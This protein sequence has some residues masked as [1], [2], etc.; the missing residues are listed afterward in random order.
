MQLE[1]GGR[2]STSVLFSEPPLRSLLPI[3]PRRR[4][5]QASLARSSLYPGK[6]IQSDSAFKI[7]CYPTR[8]SSTSTVTQNVLFLKKLGLEKKK[9]L[10]QA[11]VSNLCYSGAYWEFGII[12]FDSL[13]FLLIQ[14][15]K[16]IEEE[17]QIQE[18][19]ILIQVS[20]LC[21]SG[22][23]WESDLI[24]N[25]YFDSKGINQPKKNWMDPVCFPLKTF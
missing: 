7:H 9:Q 4:C 12:I 21:Y 18:A 23:Y 8:S 20:N 5:F 16:A 1:I 24:Q 17:T 11:Q 13:M 10:Q 14:K 15:M 19:I 3:F 25:D 6:A 22:A 2:S